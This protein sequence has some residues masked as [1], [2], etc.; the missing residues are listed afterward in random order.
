VYKFLFAPFLAYAIL[1]PVI[2][3]IETWGGRGTV[4]KSALE[5]YLVILGLVLSWNIF[6]I[7]R[8]RGFTNSDK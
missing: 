5:E 3:T 4:G 7:I 2:V 6:Q 8:K 1:I